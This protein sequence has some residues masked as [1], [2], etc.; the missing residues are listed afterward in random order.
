[1]LGTRTT[2]APGPAR[3]RDLGFQHI[4]AD[5]AMLHVEDDEL[6]PALLAIWQKP[7]VKNSAAMT[8]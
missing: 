2:G 6:G 4:Y 7:G 8:P 1:M 5:A 3:K